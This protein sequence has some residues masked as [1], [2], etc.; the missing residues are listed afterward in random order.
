[1]RRIFLVS[2]TITLLSFLTACGAMT[3]SNESS[4]GS[5]QDINYAEKPIEVIVPYDAG[6]G[7]DVIAR[8]VANAMQEFLPN[9]QSMNIV[10][11]PGATGTIGA[12]EV[13]NSENDGYTIGVL[14]NSALTIQP[15][16]TDTAYDYDDFETISQLTDHPILVYVSEDSPFETLEELIDYADENP[17][18]L[19]VGDSGSGGVGHLSAEALAYDTNVEF[20]SV[21]FDGSNPALTSL[22]GG[23]VD[24]VVSPTASSSSGLRELAIIGDTSYPELE[25]VPTTEELDIDASIDLFVAAVAP[26]DTPKEIIDILNEAFE[27]ALEEEQVQEQ[28]KNIDVE[29]SHTNSD[30]VKS[31]VKEG[32]EESGNILKEIKLTE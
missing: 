10:N 3:K 7:T 6:G 4:E 29:P 25:D 24:V 1:M 22:M 9:N 12:T 31:V 8:T 5:N 23:H 21:H 30:E 18:E 28:V 17:K 2:L 16:I 13:Y 27:K 11:R 26:K 32:Y 20:E 14:T 19:K 15:H